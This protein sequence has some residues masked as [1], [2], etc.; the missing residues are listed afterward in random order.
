M[1]KRP[2]GLMVL[3]AALATAAHTARGDDPHDADALS[4]PTETGDCPAFPTET[5]DC[6]AFPR[7]AFPPHGVGGAAAVTLAQGDVPGLQD[8]PGKSGGVLGEALQRRARTAHRQV[9]NRR[10]LQ[11]AL[12][13]VSQL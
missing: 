12:L 11:V 7:P 10:L 8:R 9:E 2:M 4:G 5:G 13:K 6:P 3:A 1:M